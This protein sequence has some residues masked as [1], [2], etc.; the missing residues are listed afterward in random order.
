MLKNTLKILDPAPEADNFQK[1]ILWYLPC[2]KRYV[3]GKNF[4]Q[5]LISSFYV[6][7]PRTNKQTNVKTSS[8]EVINANCTHLPTGH[9]QIKV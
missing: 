4:P 8:A 1:L 5:D 7:L 2:Q 6:K 9:H 3:F